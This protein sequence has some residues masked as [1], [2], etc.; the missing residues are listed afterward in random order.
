MCPAVNFIQLENISSKKD[1]CLAITV[2]EYLNRFIYNYWRNLK[3]GIVH[4]EEKDNMTVTIPRSCLKRSKNEENLFSL[5]LSDNKL[6]CPLIEWKPLDRC[7][8]YKLDMSSQYSATWNGPSVSRE[9]FTG[10]EGLKRVTF[11]KASYFLL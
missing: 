1:C 2:V 10:Q 3:D 6:T 5:V 9:I 8:K 4:D 11:H 7:R